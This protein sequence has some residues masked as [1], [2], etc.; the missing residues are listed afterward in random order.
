M[1]SINSNSW[2]VLRIA[3][4]KTLRMQKIVKKGKPGRKIVIV[5]PRMFPCKQ[6]DVHHS[7]PWPSRK[8]QEIPTVHL[9]PPVGEDL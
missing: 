3:T 4:K 8:K 1:R 7:F 6:K 9:H 2:M 5:L